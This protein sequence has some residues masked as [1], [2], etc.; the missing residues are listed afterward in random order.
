MATFIPNKQTGKT[1][2]KKLK[3]NG[4]QS[5]FHYPPLHKTKHF[6]RVMSLKNTERYATKIVNLPIHQNINTEQML[7]ITRLINE[8]NV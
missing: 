3:N 4:V 7:K 2:R 6:K 1:L 8:S 5:S